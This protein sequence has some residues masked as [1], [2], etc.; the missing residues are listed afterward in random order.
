M[1]KFFALQEIERL[2]AF[3]IL[4]KAEKYNFGLLSFEEASQ[5]DLM[6]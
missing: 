1:G 6:T 3:K 5:S 2:S 4:R